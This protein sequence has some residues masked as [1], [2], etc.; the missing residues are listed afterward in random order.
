MAAFAKWADFER[1]GVKMAEKERGSRE[2]LWW[3][4][5]G[6]SCGIRQGFRRSPTSRNR[7]TWGTRRD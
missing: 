2:T 1:V 6:V 4:R 5:H 3:A 7:E